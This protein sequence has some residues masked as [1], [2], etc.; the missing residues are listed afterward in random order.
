MVQHPYNGNWVANA[1]FGKE[2]LWKTPVLDVNVRFSIGRGTVHAGTG[3]RDS[4]K[5]WCLM[6]AVL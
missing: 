2:F 3:G 1:L 6:K 5:G 4:L